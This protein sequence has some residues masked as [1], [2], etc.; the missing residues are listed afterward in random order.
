MAD[1]ASVF[2]HYR[3]LIA[4]RQR[5]PVMA[6]GR[7]TLLLPDHPQVSAVLRTL[8]TTV[9][10]VVCNF[11]GSHQALPLA[12]ETDALA[13]TVLLGN[14]PERP[15][16]AEERATAAASRVSLQRLDLAPW[17]ALILALDRDT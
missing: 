16:T 10:L 15:G 5:H 11:S 6:E 3:R 17:E 2:H 12:R 9:W 4:L 1:P 14:L 13:G 7:T 8:G